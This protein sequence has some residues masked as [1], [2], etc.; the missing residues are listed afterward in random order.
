MS[1][2]L[3]S[4]ACLVGSVCL[5]AVSLGGAMRTAPKEPAEAREKR[6]HFKDISLQQAHQAWSL[7]GLDAHMS[8]KGLTL[9]QQVSFEI[10]NKH[11]PCNSVEVFEKE[12]NIFGMR[13]PDRQIFVQRFQLS[14]ETT[15]VAKT[16]T[17]LSGFQAQY[18]WPQFTELH[19]LQLQEWLGPIQDV[20]TILQRHQQLLPAQHR[21]PAAPTM[22]QDDVI[23]SSH[24]DNQT[25]EL[26][27]EQ[28][29]LLVSRLSLRAKCQSFTLTHPQWKLKA[30]WAYWKSSSSLIPLKDIHF[31]SKQNIDHAS[32]KDPMGS[33][34]IK[35]GI[36]HLRHSQKNIELKA[37]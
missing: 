11:F 27:I 26:R 5:V 34:D 17:K 32:L 30:Q 4:T 18:T 24:Q 22:P 21:D 9:E 1:F 6:L 29:E 20:Q 2:Q 19:Q 16:K 23:I 31:E 15:P 28:L 33:F 12:L 7:H 35:S 25:V 8:P 10:H 3:W 36:L 37:L 14:T 13:A